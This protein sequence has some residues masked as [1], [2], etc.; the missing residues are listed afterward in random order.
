MKL[1]DM[2]SSGNQGDM[3]DTVEI[4]QSSDEIANQHRCQVCSINHFK[5]R[6]ITD[7]CGILREFLTAHESRRPRF[8]QPILFYGTASDLHYVFFKKGKESD[9]CETSKR[10]HQSSNR[11]ILGGKESDNQHYETVISI[12]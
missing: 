5:E 2:R 6:R 8:I 4:K 10:S 12:L 1:L 3:V 11:Q 7:V 9:I